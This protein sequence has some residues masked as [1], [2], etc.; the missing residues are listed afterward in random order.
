M[1]RFCFFAIIYTL[2]SVAYTTASNRCCEVVYTVCTPVCADSVSL[3][4][5]DTLSVAVPDTALVAAD[6]TEAVAD[7]VLV[8]SVALTKIIPDSLVVGYI[9]PRTSWKYFNVQ[10][11]SDEDV[12]KLKTLYKKTLAEHNGAL[13]AYYGWKVAFNSTNDRTLDMYLDGARMILSRYCADTLN[14]RYDRLSDHRDELMELYDLA[15]HNL[16]K[17]N[18]Q[19]D[20]SKVK[21]TL[22]VAKFRSRQL[23]YYRDITVLDSIYNGDSINRCMPKDTLMNIINNDITHLRFM[24]P[25]YKE[26]VT[27][28]DMNVDMVDIAMFA[29]LADIRI[30]RDRE[31]G[32]KQSVRKANFEQDCEFVHK[33]VDELLAYIEDPASIIYKDDIYKDD[34]TIGRWFNS[35]LRPIDEALRYGEGRFIDVNNFEALEV[36]WAE[37]FQKEGDYDAVINSPLERHKKSETYIQA[38][39]LKYDVEPSFDL[40]RRISIRSYEKAEVRT[41]KD[42]NFADAILYLERAFKFPE[43]KSQTTF[44]QARLYMNMARYQDE[45]G[46]R[47]ST[48]TY[49]KKAKTSCPDYPEPYFMEADWVQKAKLGSNKFVNGVKYCAVYDL[50]A[51]ALAKVK[52]LSSNTDSEIKTNLKVSDIED[53]MFWCEQYFPDAAEVFMQGWKDGEKY[54]LKSQAQLNGTYNTVIRVAK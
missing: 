52:A 44:A 6:T 38:L 11:R 10:E 47:S 35:Q 46:R 48:I 39:R 26:I 24:Y 49:I 12:A 51:K 36:Y 8:D 14:H 45:A 41:V 42:K 19:L 34:V 40:A 13:N 30:V 31:T 37:K 22:S 9:P 23:R 53:L 25:R 21:D 32:L 50:Y 16:D 17:L 1:N 28:T 33:R 2:L 15:I 5:T 27:S 7:S 3:S 20:M 43:F 4:Q 54:P 18:A 29:V